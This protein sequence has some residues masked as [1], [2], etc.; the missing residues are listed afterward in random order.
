MNTDLSMAQRLGIGFGAVLLV[1]TLAIA[2]M[3]AWHRDSVRAESNYTNRIA[4]QIERVG[5]LE[6]AVFRLAVD[7]RS[8]A[9]NPDEGRLDTFRMS[10][11]T[12]REAATSLGAADLDTGART[13]YV[14][15]AAATDEYLRFADGIVA[16]GVQ[17][18]VTV[19]DEAQLTGRRETLFTALRA[20][21][22]EQERQGSAALEEIARV[23]TRTSQ[24][25]VLMVVVTALMLFVIARFTTRSVSGPTQALLRTANALI[26]GDWRPALALGAPGGGTEPEPRDE[27]KRLASAFGSA[28]V[29]LERREQ[30]LKADGDVAKA[31]GGTLDREALCDRSLRRIVEHLGAEIGAV[32]CLE[33]RTRTLH[34]VARYALGSDLPDIAV[35]DGIPG[36]AARDR[37]TVIVA[38]IPADSGFEVR[39][40]YDRAAPR[41]VAAVP[42]LF[43]DRMLG[44]LLVGS[45]RDFAHDAQAFLEAG[46]TQLGV[47]LQNVAAHEETQRLLEEVRA[48][49]ERI[50]AQNEELQVQNEEIQAQSEELQAQQEE[51]QAQNEELLQQGEE[52]RRHVAQLAEADAHKNQFLG[53]LAHELRN[54][55]TPIANS[56]YILK[57]AEPGSDS[58]AR[59][60]AVIE[61]QVT[62]LVRL[63]D[64]L[65]DV[66]RISE[67]KIQV[68]RQPLD[69][70]EIAGACVEDLSAAFA[71]RGIDV[72]ADLPDEPVEVNGDR[73]RL[74]Q[75][76]GNL[77]NNSIK[78]SAEGR[79]TLQL[80]VDH[81]NREA[82]LRVRDDGIGMEPS[83]LPKLFQPFSQGAT[84][85][86]RVNGG[87][88]LGLALVR[89][90]VTLH[91]GEVAAH[92]DGPGRG[93]EFTV[94]LPLAT[95]PSGAP[96]R[97]EREPA[98]ARKRSSQALRVLIVEDN[99]DAATTLREALELEGYQVATASSGPEGLQAVG[100]FNPD[101][102]LCDVGLPGLDGY[103]VARRL[104]ADPAARSVVLI[105]LTGYASAADKERARSAGFDLHLAKPL[106]VADFVESL[107]AL[108][109]SP[110]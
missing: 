4:P 16:R 61:R 75:V 110:N 108:E 10:A 96:R 65:L 28:A 69:L 79:V 38:D 49:N 62:H 59:A 39:L 53:V 51:I 93:A 71:E 20:L 13:L 14:P 74:S 43:Q 47:G 26:A 91:D 76:L 8:L 12:V 18:G 106:S 25:L 102:V 103:E 84:G 48:S 42:L 52:L 95:E 109:R 107:S 54:P 63:I 35:G 104:R 105:A 87:L 33:P 21:E 78:F 60:R 5:A 55:M 29:A 17:Q 37:R 23:R 36:Q 68:Q 72:V 30:R 3:L 73:T 101:V 100:A 32:Y 1:V 9:L 64:D 90:L 45:L 97:Q 83:L 98:R 70:V 24:G 2:L 81:K 66:T 34:A 57:N 58:A 94:R 77:L 46:A 56:V 82:V 15:L 92:S 19:E 41:A 31:V 89:A 40:G 80:R 50:Q 11:A 88:G 67:G 7:L 6:R 44:V 99:V 86:A 85:L 27:L 22:A